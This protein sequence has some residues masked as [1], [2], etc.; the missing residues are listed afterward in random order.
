MKVVATRI[1]IAVVA[2]AGWELGS[3]LTFA[4][5]IYFPPPS[6]VALTAARMIASGKLERNLAATLARLLGGF[7]VGAIPAIAVGWW[8][9]VSKFARDV[10]DPFLAAAHA[11]PKIA[12]FPLLLVIF[13]LGEQATIALVALSS[14]FPLMLNTCEGVRQIDPTYFDVARS[15]GASKLQTLKRVVFPG[16]LP[17][18]LTGVRLALTLALLL[19]IASEILVA[20]TGLGCLVWFS[21]E[22]LRTNEL[23]VAVATASLIGVVIRSAFDRMLLRFAPWRQVRRGTRL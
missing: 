21:W 16:S 20:R 12:I 9:G 5:Q 2:L 13:G 22:T 18:V 1:V 14:F 7:L 4:G 17:L 3:R 11:T 19:T 6:V 10:L 8:L 23:F 15:C